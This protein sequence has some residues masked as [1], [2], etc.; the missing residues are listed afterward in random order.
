MSDLVRRAD[1]VAI[2]VMWYGSREDRSS[3]FGESFAVAGYKPMLMAKL[4]CVCPWVRDGGVFDR[5]GWGGW[6]VADEL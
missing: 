4:L 1:V 2:V 3:L 6:P 5:P